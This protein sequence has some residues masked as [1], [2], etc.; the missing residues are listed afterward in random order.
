MQAG[1]TLCRL[2]DFCFNG[3]VRLSLDISGHDQSGRVRVSLESK[4]LPR[5]KAKLAS[6]MTVYLLPQRARGPVRA[7]DEVGTGGVSSL[8]CRGL[9]GQSAL[10]T[11]VSSAK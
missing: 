7:S 9:A 10:C 4:Q 1:S 5:R 6:E 8:Y 2:R 11:S 3:A